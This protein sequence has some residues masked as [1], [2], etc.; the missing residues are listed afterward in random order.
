VNLSTVTRQIY[1]TGQLPSHIML[2]AASTLLKR[3]D[4][5]VLRTTL[6]AVIVND[7]GE[8]WRGGTGDPVA[9]GYRY[10]IPSDRDAF[11][12]QRLKIFQDVVYYRGSQPNNNYRAHAR[13]SLEKILTQGDKR[14]PEV[15][16]GNILTDG[17]VMDPLRFVKLEPWLGDTETYEDSEGEFTDTDETEQTLEWQADEI[18]AIARAIAR[19]RYGEEE[20]TVWRNISGYD[21]HTRDI[22]NAYSRGHSSF[23]IHYRNPRSPGDSTFPAIQFSGN[24]VCAVVCHINGRDVECEMDQCVV[25]DNELRIKFAGHR[26]R[27][28][29]RKTQRGFFI[30][31]AQHAPTI[32]QLVQH[33]ESTLEREEVDANGRI[34]E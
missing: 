19:R 28:S 14:E 27:K 26:P 34:I 15:T 4:G 21:A 12:Q 18:I 31:Q 2:N 32:E 33:V 16:N 5:L 3:L 30:N 13:S 7:K 22:R 23:Y 10:Y 24:Q 8:P 29:I 6:G 9:Q 25:V 20:P 11:T 17:E 1:Q